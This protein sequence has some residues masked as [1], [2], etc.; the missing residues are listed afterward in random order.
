MKPEVK[1]RINLQT[2]VSREEHKQTLLMSRKT[3]R[4]VSSILRDGLLAELAMFEAGEKDA[5]AQ[6]SSIREKDSEES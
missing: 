4:S 6:G 1:R 5:E 3:G 2:L